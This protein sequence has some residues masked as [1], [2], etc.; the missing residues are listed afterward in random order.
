VT[1]PALLDVNV[2]IALFNEHH[3]HHEPA[4]DWFADHRGQPWA[5]CPLTENAFIRILSDPAQRPALVPL[6][7]LAGHLDRFCRDESHEFWP[8]GVSM[9]NEGLFNISVVRG[10]RLLTDVYLLGLAVTR[11]GRLVTFDQFIP[12]GAVKG[13]TPASLEVIAPAE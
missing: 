7:T 1:R 10:H 8:D 12:I 11:G 3:V 9:R 6:P 2:L 13:A 5:T 4:H